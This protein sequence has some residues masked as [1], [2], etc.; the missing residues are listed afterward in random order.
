MNKN[1]AG[2]AREAELL[3]TIQERQGDIRRHVGI[4]EQGKLY[5]LAGDHGK[6][7]FYYR[8][9]MNQTVNAKDPEIFF[10]HYLECVM[11]SL[12]HMG[13]FQEVLEYCDKAIELYTEKPPPNP[14]ATLDLAN[15]HQK[16]GAILLKMNGG[17]QET[18]RG[19]FEKAVEIAGT[20]GQKMPM[21]ENL[22]RW[23]GSHMHIDN[24]RLVSEQER[25]RYF[26]VRKGEVNPEIA[27]KLPEDLTKC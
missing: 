9:A 13:A 21:S 23:L 15:I 18:A 4:A 20:L 7:L 27:V 16:R 22:S 19:D 8:T 1:E 3:Q 25:T 24:Q 5:A 17:N 12:E 26:S 10:R 14:V 6:A 11:E 2:A